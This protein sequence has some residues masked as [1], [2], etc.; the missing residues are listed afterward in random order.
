VI[1]TDAANE[2]KLKATVA[3]FAGDVR[4][5]LGA[6][7]PDLQITVEK[8]S[9][10]AVL[11]PS[12]AKQTVD[13]IAS[14]H[15]GVLAMS[16]DV[17]GLVQD[18][19]NVAT[20]GLKEGAWRL[21]LASAQQLKAARTLRSGWLQ[22]PASS[23]DLRR[24]TPAAIRLEAGAEQRY[25]SQVEG[26]FEQMYGSTPNLIAMHAGLETGVL[27]VNYRRCR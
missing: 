13:L 1:V 19:T 12:D 9:A 8:A 10:G 23:P 26:S 4:V 27:G 7:D 18:S 6:F 25:R 20:V 2:S 3:Q 11:A 14:L 16:P 22:P 5:D 17:P 21:S 15:H 24:S